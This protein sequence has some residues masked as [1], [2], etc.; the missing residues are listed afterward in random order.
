MK[1][2][3]IGI[4]LMLLLVFF[5]SFQTDMNMVLR[6]GIV[7]TQIANDTARAA[8]LNIHDVAYGDGFIA[9]DHPEGIQDATDVVMSDLQMDNT[10]MSQLKFYKD[11]QIDVYMYFF[12]Q[13]DYRPYYTEYKNGVLISTNRP[14]T[15]G[16]MA[17]TYIST[18]PRGNDMALDYPCVICV[19]DTG[20]PP[21]SIA[22]LSE[23]A[24]V[25]KMGLYEYQYH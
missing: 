3:I 19:I 24:V 17:S 18:L 4:A 6:N 2:L 7:L 16:E 15:R 21:F 1:N 10:Y 11:R 8:A 9:F 13:W 23:L 20:H 25:K 12:D 14:Y 5:L 22:G